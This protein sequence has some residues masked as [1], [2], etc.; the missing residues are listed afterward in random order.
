[1]PFGVPDFVLH[2]FQVPRSAVLGNP[3]VLEGVSAIIA[4]RDTSGGEGTAYLQ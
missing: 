3:A 2:A 1:M 4:T